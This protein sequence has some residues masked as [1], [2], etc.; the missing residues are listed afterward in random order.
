MGSSTM[1]MPVLQQAHATVLRSLPAC[2]LK[3]SRH[4]NSRGCSNMK[5]TN[6]AKYSW[7]VL[8]YNLTVI[9]WGAYVRADE[10]SPF[11]IG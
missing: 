6:Y 4:L 3:I 10:V 9:L 5:L 11:F 2:P 7:G 1:I 8:I